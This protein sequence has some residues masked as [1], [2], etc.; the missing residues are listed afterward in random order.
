MKVSSCCADVAREIGGRWA[1]WLLNQVVGNV[2]NDYLILT[3]SLPTPAPLF[4]LISGG[5]LCLTINF[6]ELNWYLSVVHSNQLRIINI[7]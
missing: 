3:Y 6:D 1:Q 2:F 7:V 5:S 4:F